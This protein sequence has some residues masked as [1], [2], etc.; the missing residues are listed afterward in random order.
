MTATRD[1]L[2][3]YPEKERERTA[4]DIEILFAKRVRLKFLTV[5]CC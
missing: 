1:A 3:C 5:K 4:I 2:V